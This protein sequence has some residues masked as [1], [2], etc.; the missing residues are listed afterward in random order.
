MRLRS[1]KLRLMIPGKWLGV[2]FLTPATLF[3]VVFFV[4]P[5]LLTAVFAF[6]S[7]STATGIGEGGYL[8]T[9]STLNRLAERGMDRSVVELLGATSYLVNPET[10]ARARAAGIAA[11]TLD[12]LEQR[13]AG[14]TFDSRRNFERALKSLNKRPR[15][16]RALKQ[17]ARHF[18]TSVVNRTFRQR[19]DLLTALAASGLQ[20]SDE[21]RE[22]LVRASYTGW[23]WTTDNL[24]RMFGTADTAQVLANTLIYVFV[25]LILFNTG[26]ALV[27]AVTTFYLPATPAAVFR[28]IWF[29]PRI[30][31]PVLYV[32]LWKW[33]A[34]DTGFLSTVLVWF[35]VASRNWML[36]TAFN[37]WVFVV[38]ING[39][40]GASMGMIIF[41]SAIRAIPKTLFWASEVDGASRWQQVRRII[42]PQLRWPILFVTSYQTLSLLTSFEYILL[43]TDGG[44]GSATEVWSLAAYHTALNNYAGN[45]QYGYGATLALVL[46]IIGVAFSLLY[47]KIFNFDALVGRPR[48]ET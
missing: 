21:D 43:A 9:P 8:I 46:V 39:F 29:L 1:R 45:L 6:T 5:V 33:L 42:L 26:F 12:E 32:L 48:I 38:L 10:L 41:S 20:L 34:W 3:V 44:P 36:D 37:A 25:T 16:V 11:G 13:H 24:R 27:L 15:S 18:E 22:R 19:A 31:P 7:M 47:L 40:V 4:A 35:G 2:L 17:T 28:G 23:A 14:K 30:T